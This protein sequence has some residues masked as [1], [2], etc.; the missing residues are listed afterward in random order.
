MSDGKNQ[1]KKEPP[2]RKDGLSKIKEVRLQLTQVVHFLAQTRSEYCLLLTR[3]HFCF[4]IK[5]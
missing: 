2:T 3:H 4:D 5:K 1:I